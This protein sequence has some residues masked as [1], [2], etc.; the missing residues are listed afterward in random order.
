MQSKQQCLSKKSISNSSGSLCTLP[1][2]KSL[3]FEEK[4]LSLS[5]LLII[6]DEAAIETVVIVLL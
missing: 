6:V 2:L 4:L 5:R 1:L 3:S